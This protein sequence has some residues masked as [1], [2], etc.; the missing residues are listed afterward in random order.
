MVVTERI[1]GDFKTAFE[2]R[3]VGTDMKINVVDGGHTL[4]IEELNPF[5]LRPPPFDRGGQDKINK[6]I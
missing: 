1:D 5:G 2:S 3:A 4:S 6:K